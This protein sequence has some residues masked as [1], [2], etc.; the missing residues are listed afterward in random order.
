MIFL[1]CHYRRFEIE[2]RLFEASKAEVA[3]SG[4]QV[5]LIPEVQYNPEAKTV[6]EAW[7]PIEAEY[8]PEGGYKQIISSYIDQIMPVSDEGHK[9]ALVSESVARFSSDYERIEKWFYSEDTQIRANF[10]R[11]VEHIE[12]ETKS[13]LKLLK[14]SLEGLKPLESFTGPPGPEKPRAV[15]KYFGDLLNSLN[16]RYI[17]VDWEIGEVRP[18]TP[19]LVIGPLLHPEF[20]DPKVKVLV[21]GPFL[22]SKSLQGHQYDEAARVFTIQMARVTKAKLNM[23]LSRPSTTQEDLKQIQTDLVAK[24]ERYAS[25]DSSE[26]TISLEDFEHLRQ[27]TCPKIDVLHALSGQSEAQVLQRLE[28]L[29]LFD[30]DSFEH[31]T[32]E[33]AKNLAEEARDENRADEF[34]KQVNRY[35]KAYGRPEARGYRA[36][37]NDFEDLVADVSKTGAKEALGLI[38]HFAKNL[39]GEKIRIREGVDPPSLQEMVDRERRLM[40]TG[41]LNPEK[42]TD[43]AVID[44][45]RADGKT[46]IKMLS[47]K[48]QRERLF[49]GICEGQTRYAEKYDND[50]APHIPEDASKLRYH[51]DIK[52]SNFYG[53][54]ARL[55]AL[56]QLANEADYIVNQYS[57]HKD[58]RRYKLTDQ[59]AKTDVPDDTDTSETGLKFTSPAVKKWTPYRSKLARGGFNAV[60]LATKGVKVL[61]AL[62]VITNVA[63]AYKDSEGEDF[64]DRLFNTAENAVNPGTATGVAMV[65]GAHT[66]ERNKQYAGY[67]SASRFGREQMHTTRKLNTMSDRITPQ[68]VRKFT[69]NDA[70]WEA[71]EEL[72][73]ETVEQ[74]LKKADK[75]VVKGKPIV[76]PED[77]E[78]VVKDRSIT[79]SLTRS[80]RSGRARY[81]FYRKFLA[82]SPYPH[83]PTLR[84]HVDNYYE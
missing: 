36:A 3:P 78:S 81:L 46:R 38:T 2:R 80:L 73:S 83:I 13:E 5:P 60:D 66:F 61:G 57:G 84:E 32:R 49:R 24:Y 8:K 62:T 29:Q 30:P 56:I 20:D 10:D 1:P 23:A 54:A 39:N 68:E 31:A 18:N 55:Q 7:K 65:V 26:S 42:E 15:K 82:R 21:L 19:I 67:L 25:H 17:N 45:I 58:L 48:N 51:E 41:F 37:K 9:A 44:F 70:E 27:L 52:Y 33:A 12:Y 75:R 50:Y 76:T 14:K 6:A 72:D 47:S 43:Q 63:Q 16:Q 74:I 59:L 64:V 77:V 28:A 11:A 34:I 71:M 35:L 69:M 53:R 79:M 4:E 22:S 40:L